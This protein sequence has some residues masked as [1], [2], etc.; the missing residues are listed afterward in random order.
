M[1]PKSRSILKDRARFLYCV[2][3]ENPEFIKTELD[4]E[5]NSRKS[6]PHF[7]AE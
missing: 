6:K 7:T 1:I 3:S 2:G 4:I 5:G